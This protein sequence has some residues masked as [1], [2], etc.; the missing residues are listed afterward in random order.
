MH[1][2]T[3]EPPAD[4]KLKQEVAKKVQFLIDDTTER[5]QEADDGG[6]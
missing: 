5:V 6:S 3:K 2:L 4:E 1:T